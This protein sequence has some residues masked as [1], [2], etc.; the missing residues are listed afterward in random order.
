MLDQ[1]MHRI[2]QV[3]TSKDD[4]SGEQAAKRAHAAGAVIAPAARP[5]CDVMIAAVFHGTLDDA[6]A[7]A[8]QA[9]T[10]IIDHADDAQRLTFTISVRE[11]D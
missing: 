2:G 6:N 11:R 7:F 9:A 5:V 8:A 4:P 1:T 3:G 10:D